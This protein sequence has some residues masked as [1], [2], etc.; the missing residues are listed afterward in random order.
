MGTVRL[1]R[2]QLVVAAATG[3]LLWAAAAGV[4]LL[5]IADLLTA[6]RWMPGAA[7]APLFMVAA[8]ISAATLCA[9]VWRARHAWSLPRVALWMEE[10]LPALQY[11]AVTATD[12]PAGSDHRYLDSTPALGEVPR[13]IH[14][15]A[16]AALV[17][18]LAALLIAVSALLH[19]TSRGAARVGI[20]ELQAARAAGAAAAPGN[21]LVALRVRVQPPSYTGREPVSMA[22]PLSVSALVG[23]AIEISGEGPPDGLAAAA[24]GAPVSVSGGG[25]ADGGWQARLAMPAASAVLTLR[26]RSY[27]RAMVLAPVRDEPPA[28]LLREPARDTVYRAVPTR[29]IAL[30]A[31]ASDDI[32]MG[33]ARFEVLVSSGS[34]EV[35]KARALIIGETRAGGAPRAVLRASLSPAVLNLAPGDVISVRA[36]ARDL[37]PDPGRL[38]ATSDTRTLRIARADEY[39]AVAV[40]GAPPPPVDSVTVNRATISNRMYARGRAPDV[41][42]DVAS[43]RLRGGEKGSTNSRVA[44]PRQDSAR[45]SQVAG[46][47]RAIALVRTCRPDALVQLATLRAGALVSNPALAAALSEAI[48]RLRAGR[49]V[50]PSLARAR[51]ASSG[52]PDRGSSPRW[53]GW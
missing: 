44:H 6:R 28:V 14:R 37:N 43:V 19:V 16:A 3:A 47:L 45:A 52:A 32:G 46:L 34:G 12:S 18:E 25:A 15:A 36:V 42:V 35:Y 22:D 13:V 48:D 41:V 53:T 38:A 50:A 7:S 2:R 27:E 11:A 4:A 24:G 26:D 8:T 17:R 10:Q 29:A 39:D 20:A 9:A 5:A 23:S 21:R 40:E 33:S 31:S 30:S 51:A 49:D 1:A